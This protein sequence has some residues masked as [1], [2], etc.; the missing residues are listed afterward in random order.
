MIYMECVQYNLARVKF[1]NLYQVSWLVVNETMQSTIKLQ[2]I[3]IRRQP[4]L[5]E[6]GC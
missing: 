6:L 2:S 4:N 3:S 1:L 5:A